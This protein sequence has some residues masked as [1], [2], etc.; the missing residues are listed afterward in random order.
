[1][2]SRL[3]MMNLLCACFF[4]CGQGRADI[5][6]T[7][8]R[9]PG[10][11]L[12]VSLRNEADYAV[13][14]GVRWLV[15]KQN[16]DGSWGDTNRVHLTALALCAARGSQHPFAQDA[17]VNA[18]L[19][20]NT[21]KSPLPEDLWTHAWRLLAFSIAVPDTPERERLLARLQENARACLADAPEE[22]RDFWFEVVASLA[23]PPQSPDTPSA[24]GSDRL[25][26][27]SDGWPPAFADNRTIWSLARLI[28]RAGKGHLL[29]S[30][31]PLDWRTAFARHLVNAQ[32]RDPDAG[33]YWDAADEN[34]RI[35]ETAF[36]ILALLDL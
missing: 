16:A 19:W 25:K 27:V 7:T 3:S 14:Q 17:C 23:P 12:D 1:M 15:S 32:R 9:A 33:S 18:T 20:L 31:N 34:R 13:S 8:I 6:V 5:G 30:G 21:A 26:A 10:A 36:G 28:N 29:R 2:V 22:A 4:A 24:T 11:S 35:A